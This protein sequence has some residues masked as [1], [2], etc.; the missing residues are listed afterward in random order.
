M[1][2]KPKLGLYEFA[3][4]SF[5]MIDFFCEQIRIVWVVNLNVKVDTTRVPV[6]P[7]RPA[8]EKEWELGKSRFSG[9]RS[10]YFL[11][12]CFHFSYSF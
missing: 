2:Q 6:L 4:E 10:L 3:F 8:R 5:A 1:Q 7:Q 12:A 11:S 9:I